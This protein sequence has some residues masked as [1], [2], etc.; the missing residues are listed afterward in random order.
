MTWSSQIIESSLGRAPVPLV[1]R[2]RQ[3]AK[4]L[5]F[6]GEHVQ[7]VEAAL[8]EHGAVLFRGFSVS[9]ESTLATLFERLWAAPL[10]YVYRST[11]RTDV[12]KGV[13]T[14]TEY[15]ASQEIPM[16]NENAYQ[17]DWPMRLGF[18][19]VLPAASGG[20]TPLADVARVTERI[21]VD[22]VSEFRGRRVSYVRNYSDLI[23]LPWWTVF[24]TKSREEVEA[25]CRDHD[26]AFEWTGGGLRTQQICQG[27]AV[28]PATGGELWFNQAQL[29]HVSSLGP[30]RAASM[31]DVFGLDGLPR[32]AFFGDGQ[33]IPDSAIAHVNAA[34]AREKILFEWQKDDILVLDNMRIAHGREP[35]T[36]S[37]RVL[38]SMG[39]PHSA[40]SRASS[41]AA[42][43]RQAA[44][45]SA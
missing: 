4:L 11:P 19:C 20:Q 21:G 45:H 7:A 41:D 15:P 2:P 27:T 13:Y 42:W 31:T 16:H 6:A 24:Q 18:H 38:V 17:R 30:E 9:G 26:I 1:V 39:L 12:G 35:F 32:H 40:V 43:A 23:D 22:L 5:D 3:A 34:F 36:G 29:F 33:Q 25:Y 8:A 37:R 10:A 28:H 44:P 14:A